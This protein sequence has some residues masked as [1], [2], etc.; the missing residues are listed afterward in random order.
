MAPPIPILHNCCGTPE[1]PP[2]CS[3][4]SLTVRICRC[5]EYTQHTSR[6]KMKSYREGLDFLLCHFSPG[7]GHVSTLAQKVTTAVSSFRAIALYCWEETSVC[8]WAKFTSL[9]AQVEAGFLVSTGRRYHGKRGF[10]A[11]AG[12]TCCEGRRKRHLDS[13]FCRC[14]RHLRPTLVHNIG[15]VSFLTG[16]DETCAA[17]KMER[18]AGT[19][20]STTQLKAIS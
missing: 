20:H 7:L 17:Q 2:L 3:V 10:V 11:T 9:E 19:L 18:P 14:N 1:I 12:C 15:R 16:G 13:V 8:G 5:C 6:K 4:R